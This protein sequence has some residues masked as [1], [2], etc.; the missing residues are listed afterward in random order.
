MKS[1]MSDIKLACDMAEQIK[2]I[3]DKHGNKPGELIN[4]LHEAQHLQ[5]YLPEETQRIIASKLGIPVSKVYGVVTF[6]TFFTM[7]PKGKHPISVCMG[8]ACYVRGSEKLLE[9]FKRV[10]GIEVGDTTP[11]G[12][13]S[14]DCLRC[15]G[16]ADWLRL[17]P[18][19]TMF[20][21]AWFPRTSR[22]FWQSTNKA[23]RELSLNVMDIAQ[24]SLS[25]GASLTQIVVEE[26]SAEDTLT[27][28]I[29]DN[30]RGMTAEQAARVTDPFFTTRTTRKVGLGVPLFKMAAEQTG[31][32]FSIESEPGKGTTVTA[33]FKPS[34]IDMTPLGDI[35]ST[36]GLLI[37]S[38]PDRDFIFPPGTGME[39][40]SLWTP[41]SCERFWGKR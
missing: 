22:A 37:Y 32:S 31:G 18:L 23:M 13:F 29:I 8:T 12:K 9:E 3:C 34:H 16:A 33:V 39:G 28:K 27:L 36:V 10:L 41:G 11:D 17:S 24:N 21:A 5:G 2:T 1:I 7:T 26:S 19:T 40:A 6:Y 15:V 4:I 14:L 20:T 25:A 38:N 30:G 35:N